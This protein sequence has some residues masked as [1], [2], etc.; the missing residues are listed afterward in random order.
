MNET[1]EDFAEMVDLLIRT[2]G[3]H[4]SMHMNVKLR[5]EWDTAT[6][7]IHMGRDHG[8]AGYPKWIGFCKN[9]TLR[10]HITFEDLEKFGISRSNVKILKTLYS[11]PEDIDLIAGALL[12]EPTPGCVL[13]PTLECL[14]QHQFVLLRNSDR[15]WYENDLPPSSLTRDQLKEI[16]KVTVAGL[17]C[18]NT[19]G[20][21]KI[22]P[23]AF[24]REDTFLNVR[25]SCDQHPVPQ[26]TPWLE[27]DHMTDLTED[28]LMQAIAKAEQEVLQRRK[29]EY[30][31]W[32]TGRICFDFSC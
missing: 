7:L 21:N 20:L 12:E 22:Q 24:E 2:P 15:F 28:M 4:P 5:T 8:L 6:L 10:E 18:L 1:A 29:M 3:Q 27:M 30:Q 9:T 32:S 11:N 16:R 19:E 17:L 25:I 13:G 23:K 31:I 14:L 26:L